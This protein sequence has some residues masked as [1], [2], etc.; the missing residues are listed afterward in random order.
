MSAFRS[1]TLYRLIDAHRY[2]D[3]FGTGFD[4]VISVH[5]AEGCIVA[6]CWIVNAAGERHPGYDTSPMPIHIDALA[7]PDVVD[8]MRRIAGE[9]A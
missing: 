8:V 1:D 4:H 5:N 3:D 9:V 2:D 7:S 6:D